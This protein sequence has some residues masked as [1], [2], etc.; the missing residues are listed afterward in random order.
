MPRFTFDQR[1]TV[2]GRAGGPGRQPVAAAAELPVP[3]LALRVDAVPATGWH[4]P[5]PRFDASLTR[6]E[7]C[8]TMPDPN[9]WGTK[10]DYKRA[11]ESVWVAVK[12]TTKHV[13]GADAR[14]D[15][16]RLEELA[17][18]GLESQERNH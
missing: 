14:M 15:K 2:T 6:E 3:V 5:E 7:R 11:G 13:I 1:A 17:R 9:V 18:E 4:V 16:T 8:M 12:A 10:E